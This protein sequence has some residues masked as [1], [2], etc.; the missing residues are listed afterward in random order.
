VIAF[1]L[2]FLANSSTNSWEAAC[3]DA[4]LQVREPTPVAREILLVDGG[5]TIGAEARREPAPAELIWTLAELRVERVLLPPSWP[6]VDGADTGASASARKRASLLEQEFA[7]IDE[8]IRALFEA[9]R[10]GSIDPNDADRFVEEL[11]RIVAD[12]KSRIQKGLVRGAG[13]SSVSVEELIEAFG[14]DRLG[15]ELSEL[16]VS[17][18]SYPSAVAIPI[19]PGG[20]DGEPEFRRLP[21]AAINRYISLA[22]RLALRLSAMEEAGYFDEIDP[23]NRPSIMRD[24]LRALRE[25]LFEQPTEARAAAW[26]EAAEDYFEA[27]AGLID[28]ET[29][30]RL[31]ERFEAIEEADRKNVV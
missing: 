27:I 31:M 7:L 21:Q 20:D 10:I 12:S 28:G 19:P 22:N 13:G 24:H 15:R 26:R 1:A 8:N 18:P 23:R 2:S 9:I 16:G 3:L 6:A 14:S 30:A 25:E 17:L 5:G 29:E 4:L 11:R